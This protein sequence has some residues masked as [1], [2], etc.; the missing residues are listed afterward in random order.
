MSLRRTSP[1]KCYS[2]W[3]RSPAGHRP[4]PPYFPGSGTTPGLSFPVSDTDCT[5][6]K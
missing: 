3:Q 2:N 4:P 5:A 6:K 1:Y